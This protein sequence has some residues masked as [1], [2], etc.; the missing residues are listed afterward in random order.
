MRIRHVEIVDFRRNELTNLN[1]L[2]RNRPGLAGLGTHDAVIFINM[3][4]TQV[5]IVMGIH[6]VDVK[7]MPTARYIRSEKLRMMDGAKWNPL[8][9]AE[10][11]RQMK[12]PLLNFS[13]I[14]QALAP[15]RK[16]VTEIKQAWD[17]DEI[18]NS[19]RRAA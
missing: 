14:E 2:Y 6:I 13:A 9:I 15:L 5:V 3:M 12:I 19:V 11:A 1:I 4:H 17:F 18:I 10:Y 8:R 16:Q 7:G